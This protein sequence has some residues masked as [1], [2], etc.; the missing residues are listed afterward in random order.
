LE[1]AFGGSGDDSQRGKRAAASS[2]KRLRPGPTERLS[3]SNPLSAK[4]ADEYAAIRRAHSMKFEERGW[5]RP[6]GEPAAADPLE[7]VCHD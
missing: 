4:A 7:K 2:E 1:R 5:E 6:A 3:R